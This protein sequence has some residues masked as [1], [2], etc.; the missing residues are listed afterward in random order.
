MRTLFSDDVYEHVGIPVDFTRNNGT[1]LAN[2]IMATYMAAIGASANDP[3]GAG[4]ALVGT[5]H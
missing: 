1:V 4:S 3:L 5:P 2:H